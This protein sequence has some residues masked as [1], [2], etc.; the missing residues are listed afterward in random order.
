M[1]NS[2]QRIYDIVALIPK[3]KVLTYGVVAKIA[4]VA[5]PRIVGFALHENNDPRNIPCHRV[6]FKNG[7]LTQGYAFGGEDA[8]R[9]KLIEEGV[10]FKKTLVDLE[11]H[12]WN[13]F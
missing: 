11:K 1:K 6:V 5:T 8:Q 3:G 10:T 12:L 7:A 4:N 2:F 13:Y 9:K